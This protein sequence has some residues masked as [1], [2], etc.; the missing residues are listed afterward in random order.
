MPVMVVPKEIT[1]D[2]AACAEAIKATV[3]AGGQCLTYLR[4]WL[5]QECDETTGGI[6]GSECHH[7]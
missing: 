5:F 2:A 7:R 6:S 3:P 1:V 4:A